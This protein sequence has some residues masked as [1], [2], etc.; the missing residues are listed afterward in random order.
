MRPAW[1]TATLLLFVAVTVHAQQEHVSHRADSAGSVELFPHRETSGT[2][3]VPDTTPMFGVGRDWHGWTLMLHGR[4]FGQVLIESSEKHRTGGASG[5]Q[6]SSVNWGM[7][8]ARRPVAGGRLGFRTML[9][10]EPWTVSDCG[11][12]NLLATGEICEGD[13]IHDRQHPHDLT[14]ELA[15]DFDRELSRSLRWQVYAGLAGEPALGPAAFPHRLSAMVNPIAPISHH[16]LD[17]SHITFGLV[18]GALYSRRWK[19][20]V[21]IFN[22]R[23]PD[24]D[25]ADLDLAALDSVS[26]RLSFMANE[27]T[28][29]QV[30]SGYLNEAEAE[31]GTQPRSDLHRSTASL[32]HHRPF[33]QHGTWATTIAYGVNAGSEVLP[34]GPFEAVT[35]GVLAES[36]LMLDEGRWV[37]GRAEIVSKPAHDLHAHEYGAA[38]FS[39]AKVQAGYTRNF[40]PKRGLVPSVG[41]TVAA[42]LVP[43]ELEP[44]YS[45]RTSWSLGLFFALG[46]TKH[47]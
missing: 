35:H 6:L 20:E 27:R 31:F 7:L 30:S 38:I 5:F 37:F 13:T 40:G 14:M 12:L 34:S 9:S 22:G 21:S 15:V 2:A 10:A 29:V 36:T 25:R 32:T 47:H 17:S 46:P 43:K 8:M 24:A 1:V 33:R 11:F 44:R 26:G 16:W 42:S 39:V 28:V 41:G 45:G 18:T 3:W 19:G 4:V 23:E